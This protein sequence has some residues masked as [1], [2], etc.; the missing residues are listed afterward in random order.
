[1]VNCL[2]W[3]LKCKTS[4]CIKSLAA[5]SGQRH[6]YLS[7]QVLLLRGLALDLLNDD[8]IFDL[9]DC[10]SNVLLFVAY[11]WNKEKVK[12]KIFKLNLSSF[13]KYFFTF[14]IV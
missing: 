6:P 3:S 2:L 11:S 1:M 10:D 9:G 12:N 8:H 13:S 4:P 14:I 5:V 7:I